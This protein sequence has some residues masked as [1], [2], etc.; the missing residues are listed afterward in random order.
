MDYMPFRIQLAQKWIQG[1]GI[2]IG[3]LHLPLSVSAHAQVTYIDRLTEPELRKQYPELGNSPFVEIGLI[4]DGEKLAK[5]SDA[6]Q[7]F[8]IA[9]HFIEH[10]GDPISTLKNFL[11]VLKVGG[12]IFM[13]VP[14]RRYTFDRDRPPTPLWHLLRDYSEGPEWSRLQHFDEWCGLVSKLEGEAKEYNKQYLLSINYS[15]HYHVWSDE[16]FKELINYCQVML[17]LPFEVV[18]FQPTVAHYECTFILRKTDVGN[19]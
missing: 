3:A 12:V 9:N 6:S 5:I 19:L 17:K 4:D 14:D 13:A 11:R 7:D 8:V 18:E 2:E 10:C 16:E 1:N 15:I